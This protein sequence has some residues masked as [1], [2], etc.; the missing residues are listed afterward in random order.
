MSDTIPVTIV[1]GTPNPLC[2]SDELERYNAYIAAT[3]AYITGSNL[4]W[5]VSVGTPAPADQGKAWLRIDVNGYPKEVLLWVTASGTW[6]RIFTVPHYPVSSG[7]VANALTAT[8]N[9]T[10]LSQAVGERYWFIAAATN[11]GA[12]TLKVDSLPA[13]SIKKKVNQDLAA[14]EI[15][16]GQV[17]E[18]VWDGTNYQMVSQSSKASI[19][20]GDIAPGTNGQTL[21]TRLNLT[22]SLETIWETSDYATP[23]GSEQTLPAVANEITFEHGLKINGTKVVPSEFNAFF[24]CMTD[25][26]GFTAGRRLGYKDVYFENES[27]DYFFTITADETFVYLTRSNAVTSLITT[28]GSP[29]FSHNTVLTAGN[30]KAVAYAKI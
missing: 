24:V 28:G 1:A 19:S 23:A 14:G 6:V 10:F 18:L 9:P 15:V 8:Y 22:P 5:I 12:C 26:A 17:V 13:Y 30:W 4:Q 3:T 11:T 29:G 27:G 20:T 2:Y 25:D 16:A 7:G 21:R